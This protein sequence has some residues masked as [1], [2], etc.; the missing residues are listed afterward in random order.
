[1]PDPTPNELWN[2]ALGQLELQVTRPN[3]D[4]W[5]RNTVGLRLEGDTLVIGTPTDFALEWLRSRMQ[6]QIAR[7]VSRLAGTELHVSFEVLGIQPPPAAPTDN[8]PVS[9]GPASALTLQPD[10]RLTFDT[11]VVLESNRIAHR[12]ALRFIREDNGCSPLI[13]YG[14]PGIGKTHL[15]HA[16]AHAARETRR[17]TILLPA[18]E[19]VNRYASYVR[20][21]QPHLF[22]DGFCSC[23]V[24]LIDDLQF[25]AS[26]LGS[27]EQFFTIFNALH[28]SHKR[29]AVTCDQPPDHTGLSSH[30]RSRLQAGLAVQ[31]APPTTSD[32]RKLLEAKRSGCRYPI[33][34]AL[35]AA[36]AEL[37][38][39]S[40]RELEGALN[41][42]D[43]FAEAQGAPITTESLHHALTPFQQQPSAPSPHRVLDVVCAHFRVSQHDLAGQSRSRDITYARHIAMYLLRHDA[44]QSL[45]EIG[46][47]LGHRNHAT[48]I[49]GCK[50]INADLNN[51]PPVKDDIIRLR[52]EL[53]RRPA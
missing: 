19:F 1:M 40:V 9:A 36:I 24:L 48:V 29:I 8:P 21:G 22:R 53:N 49:A 32:R 51:Y 38:H 46:K 47:I 23:D 10:P 18:A 30:L 13:L 35:L 11:F 2:R 42:V 5:L 37:P 15:L 6:A 7:T 43:M 52:A 33:E 31:I 27:Q 4:T 39:T 14:P 20:N 44:H 3:F 26:R 17:T 25:L 12:A 28:T 16:I 45:A 41:R 34:D 50:R